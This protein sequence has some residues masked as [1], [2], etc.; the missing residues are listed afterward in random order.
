MTEPYEEDFEAQKDE[1][2]GVGH[3]NGRTF[4]VLLSVF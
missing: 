1:T 2:E 4:L 3:V